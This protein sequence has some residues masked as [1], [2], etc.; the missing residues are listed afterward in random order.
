MLNC[1]LTN[2]ESPSS[3]PSEYLDLATV[4]LKEILCPPCLSHDGEPS[5][6]GRILEW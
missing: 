2:L 1:E 5:K 3:D 4:V 6:Q